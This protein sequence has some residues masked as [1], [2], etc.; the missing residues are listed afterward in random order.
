MNFCNVCGQNQS[1]VTQFQIPFK[2]PVMT[3]GLFI[4]LG[5]FVAYLSNKIASTVLTALNLYPLSTL[6][7]TLVNF[8]YALIFVGV[9]CVG[10]RI[11]NNTCTRKNHPEKKIPIFWV[12]IP[13]VIHGVMNF[14]YSFIF[15]LVMPIV[16]QNPDL[17]L[18]VLTA[19]IPVAAFIWML[20]NAGVNALITTV[21]LR[22]VVKNK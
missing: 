3:I 9:C 4:V 22:V 7:S 21:I 15:S 12:A 18:N 1:V 5:T 14:L 2:A 19:V 20:I 13:W 11:Y 16:Y 6:A 10:F 17:N 8:V